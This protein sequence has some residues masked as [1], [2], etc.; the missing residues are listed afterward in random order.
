M[1]HACLEKSKERGEL[2]PGGSRAV[3]PC[4]KC[5]GGNSTQLCPMEV[6]FTNT[7][8]DPPEGSGIFM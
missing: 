2:D 3:Q 4:G 8:L 5:A 7:S 1:A 6:P